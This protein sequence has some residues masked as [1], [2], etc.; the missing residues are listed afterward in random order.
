MTE[1]ESGCFQLWSSWQLPGLLS[2]YFSHQITD[3]NTWRATN[4]LG[5]NMLNFVYTWGNPS[6]SQI[7][8]YPA[9]HSQ[10]ETEVFVCGTNERVF[11]KSNNLMES[12]RWFLIRG[13]L[14]KQAQ[15]G[16]NPQHAMQIRTSSK[17]KRIKVS[18]RDVCSLR[19]W[20]MKNFSIT[21]M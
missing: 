1:A 8:N 3:F 4:K 19:E 13:M 12:C 9:L 5:W 6:P 2:Q 10:R 15:D 18:Y 11:T 21:A 16:L 14:R 20:T 17:L 7:Q